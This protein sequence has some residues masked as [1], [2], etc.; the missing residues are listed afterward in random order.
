MSG[1]L[2]RQHQKAAA[3]RSAARVT[4]A[5]RMLWLNVLIPKREKSPTGS[6]ASQPRARLQYVV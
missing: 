6:S 4:V 1:I 5:A 2:G 3:I